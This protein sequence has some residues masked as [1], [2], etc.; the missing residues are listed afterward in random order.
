ML[1]EEISATIEENRSLKQSARGY[2]EVQAA[3]AEELESQ[4]T[5]LAQ[6][7]L[8]LEATRKQAVETVRA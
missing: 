2:R 4:R 3:A 7:R 5:T 1:S 6:M 8:D